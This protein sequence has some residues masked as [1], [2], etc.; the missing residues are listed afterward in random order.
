M[1][2]LGDLKQLTDVEKHA[3]HMR[4]ASKHV[5]MHTFILSVLSTFYTKGLKASYFSRLK[6]H[7][8]L[9]RKKGGIVSTVAF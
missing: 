1:L 4:F 9:V 6:K 8:P 2:L 3:V 7:Q 5:S